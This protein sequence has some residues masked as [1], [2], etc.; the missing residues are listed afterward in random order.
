MNSSPFVVTPVM[1]RKFISRKSSSSKALVSVD[2]KEN[3]KSVSAQAESTIVSSQ[4]KA[5]EEPWIVV[6]N[7]AKP[8]S[9]LALCNSTSV[10]TPAKKNQQVLTFTVPVIKNKF[11]KPLIVKPAVCKP[12]EAPESIITTSTSL[13]NEKR[14]NRR[15]RKRAEKNSK[16]SSTSSSDPYALSPLSLFPEPALADPVSSCPDEASSYSPKPLSEISNP[17]LV[18]SLAV[19]PNAKPSTERIKPSPSTSCLFRLPYHVTTAHLIGFLQPEDI[20]RFGQVSQECKRMSEEGYLWRAVFRGRFPLSELTPLALR[21]W[22][23]AYMLTL[24]QM[25]DTL[26]C[27]VTK[28]TFFEDVL[29]IPITYTTNPKTHRI[30]YISSSLDLISLT[31]FTKNKMRKDVWG[32]EFSLLL[33]LYFTQNHFERGMPHLKKT[34]LHLSSSKSSCFLPSMALEV[35]PK[36]INTFVVLLVDEGLSSG[37]KAFQGFVWV[38]RVFL[39]L[40]HEY[41]QIKVEAADKVRAFLA[42]ESNRS[43]AACPSLGDFVPLLLVIDE[44][45]ASW[46]LI[47][48]VLIREI[49]DRNVLWLCKAHPQLEITHNTSGEVEGAEKEE[50]RIK[51]SFEG[52]R[53]SL[54]LLMFQSY[55]LS[56]FARGNTEDRANYYDRFFGQL[57]PELDD[58]EK[59]DAP[60]VNAHAVSSTN[61]AIASLT[62]KTVGKANASKPPPIRLSLCS[63]KR[64]INRI[65]NTTTWPGFFALVGLP[66]LSK[67]GL[68][69]VLRE[70]VANS[71]RKKYHTA[72]MDFSR[73]QASGSSAILKKGESYKSNQ[74]L[75]HV[76][77][78]DNWNFNVR[79][80]L[81][82]TVL[83]YD[84]GNKELGMVDFA[85]NS[86]FHGALQHSG[87]IMTENT[88]QHTINIDLHNL[89][90]EVHTLVFVLSAFVNTLSDVIN[91]RVIF[92]ETGG[93][94]LCSYDLNIADKTPT[95]TAVV[96][97]TLSR[98]PQGWHVLA[99]GEACPGR[100]SAYEPIRAHVIKHVLRSR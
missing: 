17:A 3:I 60:A 85:H 53:V 28:Q 70:A 82:A 86:A 21:E 25:V 55:F 91:P 99:V 52:S 64:A 8:L 24:N 10:T 50:E 41:P 22:R 90:K 45:E 49:F 12:V 13:A 80:Y 83:C 5:H 23:L 88:G 4:Q 14:R 2:D 71:R 95:K 78:E 92:S 37:Q 56:S 67:Q 76:R 77:F 30:D 7:L 66:L 11:A 38:H 63:F 57:E 89:P 39:A 68:A 44:S 32:N 48:S 79:E 36:L 42:K 61:F 1:P 40:A 27:S 19:V 58:D 84:A 87:D 29:G 97:C 26:R 15:T 62:G 16:P 94:T 34:L 51:L 81:D 33:P 6:G 98:M 18:S 100:A 75:R 20:A 54:K 93:A 43:K 46:A 73:V 65:L 74:G 9:N 69:Q 35:L 96:M 59:G 31:A 72:G 47:R